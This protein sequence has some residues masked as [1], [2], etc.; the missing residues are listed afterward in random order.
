MDVEGVEGSEGGGGVVASGAAAWPED[1][2]K[3]RVAATASD[4]LG[5]R[6]ARFRSAHLTA[7]GRSP[8]FCKSV[9]VRVLF[10][11]ATLAASLDGVARPPHVFGT[12]DA[13]A[14]PDS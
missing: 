1:S 13:D 7:P 6:S 10:S 12:L 3:V 5:S 14:R 9:D 4:F 11:R 2:A 8:G